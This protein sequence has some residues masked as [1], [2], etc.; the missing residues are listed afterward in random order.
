V[1]FADVKTIMSDSGSAL[2]GIGQASGENRAATAA[3]MAVS[4]PLLETSIDGAKGILYNII[5]GSD[6]S[7]SEVSDA[8]MIIASAAA[9]DANI[10][11]GATINEELGS[12]IKISVIA[13][14]FDE[15]QLGY[16]A[17]N[18]PIFGAFSK[19][20]QTRLSRP[21]TTPNAYQNSF[22]SEPEPAKEP[23]I[24]RA[25]TSFTQPVLNTANTSVSGSVGEGF[26]MSSSLFGQPI[27]QR[28]QPSSQT[29]TTSTNAP[30]GQPPSTDQSQKSSSSATLPTSQVGGANE[31]ED[32]F[33]VPAFLRNKK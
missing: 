4:S 32:E 16:A 25:P 18:R 10:I 29:N 30:V 7:M 33:D 2:M 12:S 15:R 1:D 6:L 11:F 22:A 20:S 24:D 9:P 23:K 3:R 21:T 13:T 19:D 17:S 14:G 5:G 27:I 31:F 8:S 28:S 26:G